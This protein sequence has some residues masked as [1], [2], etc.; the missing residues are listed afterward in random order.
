MY[1]EDADLCH[2]VKG[3]G[4]GVNVL[5]GIRALH[6]VASSSGGELSKLAIYFSDRNR[7]ILSRDILSTVMR[8][9]FLIYKAA[10]NIVITVKFLLWQ[11][12]DLVPWLWRGFFHGLEGRTGYREILDRLK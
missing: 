11:G 3:Q 2:R 10:A 7:I 12:P 9:I 8:S 4:F 5:P 1:Y 6:E